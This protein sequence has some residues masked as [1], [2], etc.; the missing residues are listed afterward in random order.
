MM[1]ASASAVAVAR[2]PGPGMPT[3]LAWQSEKCASCRSRKRRSWGRPAGRTREGDGRDLNTRFLGPVEE[4]KRERLEPP[5]WGTLAAVT[6][7]G[8]C[9]VLG[10]TAG[11]GFT[12]R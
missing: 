5:W 7:G 11:H 10:A 9:A 3:Q 2:N 4:E 12:S 8:G 6:C 1:S